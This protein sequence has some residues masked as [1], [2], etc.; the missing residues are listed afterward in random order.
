M[1][2]EQ[3]RKSILQLAIQG[4]LVKQDP[5]DEPASVLLER[6]RVEKQRL[7][8]E[9]KIKKD[10]GDSIIFK[11]DDNCYYEKIGAEVKNIDDEIPF[12]IPDTWSFTRFSSIIHINGGYAFKSENYIGK[13]NGVRVLRISDFNEDGFNQKR[14][15]YHKYTIEL[16][17]FE[18]EVNDIIMCMTGG[19]VGKSYFV[20]ELPE[21]MLVNQRVADIKIND[22]LNKKYCYYFILSPYIQK[23]I[24]ESK[25]ST[26]DNIS[27]ALINSFIIPVP[28]IA[29]Q[30]RIVKEIE[31]F[32][33]LLANYDNLEQQATKLDNEIYEKLK[34]SI[35]QYA[36]QGKLVEQDENDEPASALLER[37]R[38][39]KKAQLGKKYIES[40]IYKGDD[41]CYYEKNGKAEPVLVED[42]PFDI[43][44]TW[45]WAR[46]KD[47][48]E[49][50]PR[51]SVDDE[52]MVSFVEM[53]SLKDG[54]NNSFVYEKR[55]WKAVKSGFT[56]FQNGDVGFAKITPCFQNRKSAIFYELENG[57]GAGTT[58]LHILRPHKNTMLA[59]YL[60]WFVK[61]PY[62]IEYGKQK[63]SGTAGQQRFGTDE[64]KNTLIPI[65]PQAEQERI[66]IKIKEMLSRIEKDES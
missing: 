9:G 43:P 58:E 55:D 22:K 44:D 42:L 3:L 19:T 16:K 8:K 25:N 17:S 33:P 41:N 26:N 18:L 39:E 45:M 24:D 21:P 52:T 36:I 29:E 1:K 63:F 12:E 32:E 11:G 48:V 31:R 4:K 28:P 30:E 64:V 47:V 59:D 57:Y 54:F 13:E 60:L 65:P 15:V 35:L 2:A 46:L 6:I 66:C 27:V 49:I 14:P 20:E 23:I 61:S 7:I 51:N 56:H 37:I 40:Y 10:K 50:N 34:K 5:N 62:L 53:K 38:A